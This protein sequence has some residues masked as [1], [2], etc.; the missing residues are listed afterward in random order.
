[1]IM[2]VFRGFLFGLV[3]IFTSDFGFAVPIY[4]TFGGSVVLHPGRTSGPITSVTWKHKTD[5]ALEWF[6]NGITCYRTFQGRCDLNKQ[7]GSFS[8]TDLTSEDSGEYTPEMNNLVGRTMELQVIKPV[9]KP[10]VSMNCNSEKTVCNL[11][12]EANINAEFGPVTYTWKSGDTELSIDKELN[13]TAKNE[14]SSYYCMLLNPVSNSTSDEISDPISRGNSTAGVAIGVVVVLLLLIALGIAAWVM[15]KRYPRVR[16]MWPFKYISKN[17]NNA[18]PGSAQDDTALEEGQNLLKVPQTTDE[19]KSK[20][21][22]A[23]NGYQPVNNDVMN[24]IHQT[25]V[26][27]E[28]QQQDSPAEQDSDKEGE[29]G[30]KSKPEETEPTAEGPEDNSTGE[31]AFNRANVNGDEMNNID[32]TAEQ[33]QQDPP[34]EQVSDKEGESGQ[35]SESEE[36]EPTAEGPEKLNDPT[37]DLPV[38]SQ[39]EPGSSQESN[40]DL[41]A[42]SPEPSCQTEDNSTGEEAFNR[43]NVNGDEM[44]NIDQTAVSIEQQQQD[45]PVEQDSDNEGESGQKSESE[46][47]E[48]TAEGP[49]T[50]QTETS[51]PKST[52]EDTHDTDSAES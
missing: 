41:S 36:T 37:C 21:K 7:T 50:L 12:C 24:N 17:K 26:S 4:K 39:P 28:Q 52:R 45:P 51:L 1:M 16:E 30:Q 48:P 6:G 33:Q 29:S 46:E 20:G 11:I 25:V 43:A 3:V 2:F 32:Q 27:I 42:V 19:N 47:T 9:P 35:K 38:D 18:A 49:D 10:T 31:E 15:Y 8:I 5:L 22:A 23:L 14:E 34:A 13:I 40:L 44:N